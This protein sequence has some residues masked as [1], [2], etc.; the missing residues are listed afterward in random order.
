M[1]QLSR[2][3][4]P[5]LEN[6][7][8]FTRCGNLYHPH[9]QG[10]VPFKTFVCRCC[11]FKCPKLH[12]DKSTIH[13]RIIPQL[14]GMGASILHIHTSCG[15]LLRFMTAGFASLNV[16]PHPLRSVVAS[17]YRSLKGWDEVGEMPGDIVAILAQLAYCGWAW[18]RLYISTIV[19]CAVYRKYEPVW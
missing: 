1:A 6:N 7:S 2:E 9:L 11:I 19:A 8:T 18:R 4:V 17:I 12:F 13:W 3:P 10:V 15:N 5:W 14:D 16:H